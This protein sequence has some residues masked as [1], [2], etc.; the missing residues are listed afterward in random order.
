M[1]VRTE[2]TNLRAHAFYGRRGFEVV[3][4]ATED[5]EGTVVNVTELCRDLTAPSPA[6]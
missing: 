5:I 6:P 3:A 1:I 4:T 2:T